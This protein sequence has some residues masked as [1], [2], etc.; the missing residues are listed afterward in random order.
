MIKK[1]IRFFSS[2]IL[3]TSIL[4]FSLNQCLPKVEFWIIND[5]SYDY[6]IE[7]LFKRK[8][9][10]EGFGALFGYKLEKMPAIA[11][12]PSPSYDE[13]F[14][15]GDR[16]KKD[17]ERIT[18]ADFQYDPNTA[19]FSYTLKSKM[20]FLLERSSELEH[21]RGIDLIQELRFISKDGE[22]IYK[23]KEI[24][25]AFLLSKEITILLK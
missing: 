15:Q 16:F 7:I 21:S 9:T 24:R 18:E 6:K 2:K 10:L 25:K 14:F 20:S 5:S 17:A 19:V 12:F 11:K 8:Y 1:K 22:I 4:L 23:G 13:M 3:L